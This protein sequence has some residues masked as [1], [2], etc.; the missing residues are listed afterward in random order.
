MHSKFQDYNFSLLINFIPGSGLAGISIQDCEIKTSTDL[1]PVKSSFPTYLGRP[2]KE[3]SRTVVMQSY[4]GDHIDLAGWAEW[5]G[6]FALK[7]LYYGEYMNRGPGAG[8]SKRVKWR[9]YHVIKDAAEAMKFT[10]KE[11]IQGGSWLSSSGVSYTEG[12]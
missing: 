1:E 2:W 12:L 8:T 9:G 7:T 11:L 5:S 3:Y 6:D 10:V 4:I